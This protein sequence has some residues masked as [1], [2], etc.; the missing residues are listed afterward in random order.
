[1]PRQITVNSKLYIVQATHILGTR[2]VVFSV[3]EER[4]DHSDLSYINNEWYGNVTSR[5][6]TPEIDALQYRERFD[7]VHAYCAE[8]EI[9]VYWIIK[10]AFP[11]VGSQT[12]FG[13]PCL[14]FDTIQDAKAFAAQNNG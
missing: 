10:A 6:I 1:M 9:E 14:T 2:E 8:L 5:G 3:W 11:E 13:K 7:A 4:T 12:R